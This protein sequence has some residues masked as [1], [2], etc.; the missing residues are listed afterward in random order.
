MQQGILQKYII[1]YNIYIV[2]I[3]FPYYEPQWEWID[4]S[5]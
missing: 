5:V 3:V 1:Y 4:I 2:F